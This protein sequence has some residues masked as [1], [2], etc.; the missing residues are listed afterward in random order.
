[1]ASVAFR[2]ANFSDAMAALLRSFALLLIAVAA[3]WGAPASAADEF[4]KPEEA[5]KF[6]AR[7]QD[8]GTVAVTYEIADAYYMYRER[9]KFT[10][11]GAT[12][13]EPSFRPGKSNSTIPSRRTSRPIAKPSPS[14]FRSSRPACSP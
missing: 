8:A 5:F 12:L 10:A 7:M 6:S 3:L 9:F 11:D 2:S 14:P 4:L 1:M 13:G